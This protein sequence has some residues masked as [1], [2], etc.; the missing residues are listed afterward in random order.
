MHLTFSTTTANNNN[1]QQP[2][3]SVV[4]YGFFVFLQTQRERDRKVIKIYVTISCTCR[5]VPSAW[6][7]RFYSQN[8]SVPSYSNDTA[9][10]LL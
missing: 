7:L 10:S 6:D 8:L 4:F 3:A 1:I 5:A 9:L 2:I